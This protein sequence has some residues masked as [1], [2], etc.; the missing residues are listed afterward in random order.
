[1][2]LGV[3]TININLKYVTESRI[4]SPVS[5]LGIQAATMYLIFLSCFLIYSHTNTNTVSFSVFFLFHFSLRFCL[6][7][8]FL[9]EFK[10]V[11]QVSLSSGPYSPWQ[12]CTPVT[13][14][15]SVY[16]S[17]Q[18]AKMGESK[19]LSKDKIQFYFFPQGLPMLMCN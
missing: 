1:M 5:S 4:Q 6:C 17:I 13:K 3:V 8:L 7:L 19:Q 12:F 14:Q 9:R 10:V 15:I 18:G 11:V 2:H 16:V